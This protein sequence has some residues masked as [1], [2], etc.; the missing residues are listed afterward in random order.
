MLF[1]PTNLYN[2][3]KTK[4][5]NN[6]YEKNLDKVIDLLNQDPNANGFKNV[7]DKDSIKVWKKYDVRTQS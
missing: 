3:T 1:M 6:D 2:K 5:E 7:Y 4:M